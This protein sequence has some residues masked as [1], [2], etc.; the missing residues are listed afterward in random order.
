MTGLAVDSKP[1]A[2]AHEHDEVRPLVL[3][4]LWARRLEIEQ[5]I[6]KRIHDGVPSPIADE[7]YL[8]GVRGTVAASVD[9]MLTGVEVRGGSRLPVPQVV[10]GQARRAARQRVGLDIVLRRCVAG[11]V[12]LEDFIMQEAD[13]LAFWSG[14][15]VRQILAASAALLDCLIIPITAAYREEVGQSAPVP[16]ASN[17]G[18]LHEEK[19]ALN[20]RLACSF[21]HRNDEVPRMFANPNASRP[22]ECLLFL[23]DYPGSSNREIANGIG[24]VHPSQISKLLST[25]AREDLLTKRSEGMGKRNVWQ[26]TARGKELS[27]VLREKPSTRISRT[28]ASHSSSFAANAGLTEC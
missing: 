5:T 27:Q 24:V 18:P 19:I 3:E 14:G 22:R 28:Y 23:D 26:L 4:R 7:E 25:L 11:Y 8:H 12:T 6:F 10:L 15:G 17:K 2:S 16:P 9:Y 21:S 13:H 1:C 20:D